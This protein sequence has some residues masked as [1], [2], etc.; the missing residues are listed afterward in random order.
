M[1]NDTDNMIY[2]GTMSIDDYVKLMDWMYNSE[3][4]Q[5]NGGFLVFAG[6]RIVDAIIGVNGKWETRP[7]AS[8][9]IYYNRHYM[10]IDD[11]RDILEEYISFGFWGDWD[12]T[13]EDDY[14]ENEAEYKH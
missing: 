13:I 11:A 14:R 4:N 12:R 2:M 3:E 5:H 10:N 9:E 8:I 6:G 7:N 1:L